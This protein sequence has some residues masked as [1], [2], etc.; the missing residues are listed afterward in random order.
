MDKWYAD[1]AAAVKCIG[2]TKRALPAEANA[3]LTNLDELFK[4]LDEAQ[5]LTERVDGIKRDAEQFTL[6]VQRMVQLLAPDS[7]EMPVELAA[8]ELAARF[9]KAKADAAREAELQKQVAENEKTRQEA[10]VSIQLMTQ[11]L[12]ELCAQASCVSADELESAEDR[13]SQLQALRRDVDALEEQLLDLAAGSALEQFLEEAKAADPDALP[14]EITEVSRQVEAL[15]AKR[16]ELDQTVGSE[17]KELE[18]MDGSAKAAE[19]AEKAESALASIRTKAERY[20]RL[21][22][23]ATIL[24]REIERYRQQ[25]QG[26]LLGRA[27][28]LFSQLTL[29]SFSGLST[30]FGERDEPVLFGVRPSGERVD[31]DGMSDGTLDQLYLSLRLASLEKYLQDN[32]PMPFVVDDILIRFDDERAE[33]TL[34]VLA[35]LTSKTQ[36]LFFTHH[37]RLV[38][39]AKKV[40]GDELVKVHRLEPSH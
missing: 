33:A 24:R 19:A 12:D 11:Q 26:P 9:S 30:D 13:S 36:V 16:S 32:E 34:R 6:H 35:A 8:A 17:R 20:V 37:S 40:G 7:S 1:W 21:R 15:Q 14:A 29:Q 25:N 4:K 23:A 18:R 27:S 38:E 39:I 31:V 10:Q 28:E 22:L 2:L 3:V 5:G